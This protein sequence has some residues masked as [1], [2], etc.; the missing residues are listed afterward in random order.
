MLGLSTYLNKNLNLQCVFTQIGDQ[1]KLSVS[2]SGM[3]TD[4]HKHSVWEQANH[5]LDDELA[6]ML[7]TANWQSMCQLV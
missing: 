4:K 3:T 7:E 5:S 2:D 6:G 1:P